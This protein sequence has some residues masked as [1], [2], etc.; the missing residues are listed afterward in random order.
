M[1]LWSS[2]RIPAP[3]TGWTFFT[4]ICCKKLECLFEKTKIK[5]QRGRGW[6][7]LASRGVASGIQTH[8]KSSLINTR[9][10]TNLIN[11]QDRNL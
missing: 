3:Y 5:Q 9:P 10:V 2:V 1:S 6:P 11:R 7:I 4:Y 8:V